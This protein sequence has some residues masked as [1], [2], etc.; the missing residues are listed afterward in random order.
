MILLALLLV[1]F[2]GILTILSDG[3]T[4]V[5]SKLMM[6]RVKLISLSTSIINLLIS[7]II[8]ILFDFSS[9]QYQFVQEYHEFSSYH[10]Y[11]GVDGISMYFILLTT[12]ITPI[13]LLSN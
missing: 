11:L 6:K 9:N 12:I 2:I 7:L 4:S 5:T 10:I 8:F 13:A 1:P 3:Y